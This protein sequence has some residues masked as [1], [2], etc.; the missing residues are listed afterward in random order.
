M[1]TCAHTH[2][3]K[4]FNRER[5]LEGKREGSKPYFDMVYLSQV[6]ITMVCLLWKLI[7]GLLENVY[8]NY[9]H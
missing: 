1:Q 5:K 9:S 7:T 6:M 8:L 3:V 4:D 2:G